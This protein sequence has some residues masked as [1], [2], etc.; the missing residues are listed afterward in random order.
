M[1]HRYSISIVQNHLCSNG[2]HKG[3]NHEEGCRTIC[4]CCHCSRRECM[5]QRVKRTVLRDFLL[6]VFVMNHFPPGPWKYLKCPFWIFFLNSRR[7]LQLK[8]NHLCQQHQWQINRWCQYYWHQRLIWPNITRSGHI[9][10]ETYIDWC[11][12]ATMST[13]Q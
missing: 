6:Q 7:Y 12:L 5:V 1:L 3:P 8:V 11:K 2:L 4:I 10:T 13:K 9:L